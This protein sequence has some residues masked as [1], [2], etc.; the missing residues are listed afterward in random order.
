M[1]KMELT[2]KERLML[3]EKKEE[4]RNLTTQILEIAND[5]RQATEIKKKIASI[6]SNLSI[7]G[8][9]AKPRRN[10]TFF[11]HMADWIFR[12]INLYDPNTCSPRDWWVSFMIEK[13]CILV[14][15]IRFEFSKT[16]LKIHIP[17]IDI[18]IFRIEK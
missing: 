9:Y 18:S 6:L 2:E 7:I 12:Q 1:S 5:P 13:F 8:S 4:I 11:T 17:K 10:L 16:G 15:S 14:N 3:V